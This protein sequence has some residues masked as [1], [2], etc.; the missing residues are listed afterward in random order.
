MNSKDAKVGMF[1][2]VKVTDQ[3]LGGILYNHPG[4][5]LKIDKYYT[6]LVFDVGESP[7]F[8]SGQVG[9]VRDPSTVYLSNL[10]FGDGTLRKIEAHEVKTY[11]DK[12]ISKLQKELSEVKDQNSPHQL[13]TPNQLE[14]AL[15]K[16]Q[17]IKQ[18]FLEK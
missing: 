10:D 3:R 16:I 15:K 14:T 1:V 11:L 9:R 6:I 12:I 4:I 8:L 5:I 18:K 2:W 17:E 7:R 13:Y